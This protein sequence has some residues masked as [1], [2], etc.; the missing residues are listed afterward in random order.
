MKKD[1]LIRI[2]GVQRADGDSDVVEVLTTGSFCRR[3]KGY[4]II[5]DESEATGFNGSKTVLHYDPYNS[6]VTM[7][8]SGSTNSR[9]VI[10]QGKRHQCNYDTG[11]GSMTVGI[12]GHSLVSHLG[13][14]GGS[15]SFGYSLDL[16]TALA[17]E[18]TVDI[19]VAPQPLNGGKPAETAA[20]T[21]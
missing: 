20:P 2:K 21:V 8:R 10:E 17:S 4:Y 9:M 7:S 19:L 14:E 13:D 1:V 5:Y 18:H 15:L 12:L 3:E 6:R 11:F 16:N